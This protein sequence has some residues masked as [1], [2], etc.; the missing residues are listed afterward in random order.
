[1]ERNLDSIVNAT[2]ADT[3]IR[4]YD[5]PSLVMG[6]QNQSPKGHVAFLSLGSNVGDTRCH[7]K[8]ARHALAALG[9]SVEE[10]SAFY[11]TEPVDFKDQPWFLNQVIRVLTDL[12]PT[13]LLQACLRTEHEQ[14]RRRDIA[15]GPRTL[16]ID[17][18]LYDDLILRDPDLEIPHPGIPLRRFVL[19]PL[20]GL[21]PN[22]IHPVLQ[23]TFGSLLAKCKDTSQVHRLEESD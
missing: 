2:G 3:R 23:D 12:T 6:S 19:E 9:V 8:T 20:A 15:K 1:V 7:L 17:I 18:L 22:K 4:P 21:A 16:D 10:A 14:G 13:E 11:A 5:R